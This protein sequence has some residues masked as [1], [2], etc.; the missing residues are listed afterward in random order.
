[1]IRSSRTIIALVTF[2]V[3]I[4]A[5][6]ASANSHLWRINEI[7]SNDDGTVQFIELQEINGDDD[8]FELEGKWFM[9][10]SFQYFFPNDLPG[11]TAHRQFLMATQGFADIP[12]APAPDYIIPDGFIDPTGDTLVYFIYDSFDVVDGQLPTDGV[13]SL[14]R[15]DLSTRANSPINFAG[16]RGS[17]VVP[18]PP[19]MLAVTPSYAP[20]SGLT[21]D[22]EVG[23]IEPA[24]WNVWIAWQTTTTQ[25]RST[26]IPVID[27]PSPVSI[28]L[29]AF[30]PLG[31]VGVLT[32]LTTPAGITCSAWQT[33]DTAP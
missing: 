19:C 8:E 32:S 30:P 26:G 25:I 6:T 1:M 2:A 9:S 31:N 16:D 28:N 21:L 29:A 24:T 14:D 7:Y 17:I 13:N 5:G 22:F 33:V 3:A 18:P 27:P 4:F 12:G 23:T 10:D 20:G 15:W 11:P